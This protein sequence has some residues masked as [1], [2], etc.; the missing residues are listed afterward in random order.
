MAKKSVAECEKAPES[1][2]NGDKENA[3]RRSSMSAEKQEEKL[4]ERKWTRS[5]GQKPV[6][7][8][9]I[10][11]DPQINDSSFLIEPFRIKHTYIIRIRVC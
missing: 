6:T 3:I 4:T 1:E 11:H 5:N 10:A 9:I 2:N 8:P 7:N